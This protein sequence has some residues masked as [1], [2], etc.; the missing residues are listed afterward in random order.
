MAIFSRLMAG[1]AR[2][3]AANINQQPFSPGRGYMHVIPLV[4]DENLHNIKSYIQ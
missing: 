2:R 3:D 1:N 4:R